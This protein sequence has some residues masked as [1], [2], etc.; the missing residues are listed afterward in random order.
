MWRRWRTKGNFCGETVSKTFQKYLKNQVEYHPKYGNQYPKQSRLWNTSFF[1][2]PFLARECRIRFPFLRSRFFVSETTFQ[3]PTLA[4]K[5]FFEFQKWK[6][7]AF[8]SRFRGPKKNET[9][10]KAFF[11]SSGATWRWSTLSLTSWFHELAEPFLTFHFR[12]LRRREGGRT[13]FFKGT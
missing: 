2:A 4:L 6:K 1:F 10:E 7:G 8:F 13:F 12:S 11:P 9:G 3:L 5:F